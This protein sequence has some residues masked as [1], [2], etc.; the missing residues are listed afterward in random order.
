MHSIPTLAIHVS[1]K[2]G[3]IR[4]RLSDWKCLRLHDDVLVLARCVT[5]REVHLPLLDWSWVTW[6]YTMSFGNIVIAQI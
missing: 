2:C 4:Y 5:I 1:L 3:V 6:S